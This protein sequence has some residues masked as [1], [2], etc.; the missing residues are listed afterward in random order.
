MRCWTGL[1]EEGQRLN[2]GEWSHYLSQGRR[3]T[4]ARLHMGM[5]QGTSPDIQGHKT[6]G[7]VF[8]CSGSLCMV[9]GH[10]VTLSPQLWAGQVAPKS[11][12]ASCRWNRTK[13]GGVTGVPCQ[14]FQLAREG[15]LCC[16]TQHHTSTTSTAPSSSWWAITDKTPHH[17]SGRQLW[18]I[19]SPGRY[20]SPGLE[21]IR[22]P[23]WR[24]EA[25]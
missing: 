16:W 11:S 17:R 9:V 25:A 8:V 3:P 22:Q 14:G 19:V 24:S 21:S 2:H 4:S 7:W 23:V 18:A 13:L 10:R 15:F 1:A 20:F 12:P 5:L 6:H